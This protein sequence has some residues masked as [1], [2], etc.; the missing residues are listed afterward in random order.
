M[1][2]ENLKKKCFPFNRLNESAYLKN[3]KNIKIYYK[4][5]TNVAVL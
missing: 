3:Q 2:K 1:G 5:I 4:F